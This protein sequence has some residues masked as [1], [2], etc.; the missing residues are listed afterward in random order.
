MFLL[1]RWVGT[2]RYPGKNITVIKEKTEKMLETS[3]MHL[4]IQPKKQ[5][6]CQDLFERLLIMALYHILTCTADGLFSTAP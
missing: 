1:V 3:I 4:T 5:S 6:C 2:V